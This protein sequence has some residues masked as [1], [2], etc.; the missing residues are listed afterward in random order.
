MKK[1][2]KKCEGFTLI[3]TI[4]SIA[5]I[6]ML[7]V[8][9]YNGY[10]LLIRN[11]KYG[12]NK[13]VSALVGKQENETIK[14]VSLN[15]EFK[16][17]N[18]DGKDI[19]D[20]G[21]GIK[22]TKVGDK[23]EGKRYFDKD[24]QSIEDESKKSYTSDITLIPKNNESG[25][26]ISLDKF[27][28][29]SNSELNSCDEYIVKDGGMIKPSNKEPDE[30]FSI[31]SEITIKITLQEDSSEYK[32]NIEIESQK[33]EFT[34][35]KKKNIQLNLDLKYCTKSVK[36][37]VKNETKKP[38]NLCILNNN[39]VQ[40]ENEKGVLNEYYRSEAIN[41]TGQLFEVNV[42]VFDVKD[43]T[44]PLYSSNFV[45]NIDIK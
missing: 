34:L 10:V 25:E 17:T 3:E 38:L 39:D 45:Q 16:V 26:K 37:I 32:G 28:N 42:K 43:E 7:S 40:V 23:Y 31:D 30:S 20:M 12:E 6:G 35:E 44:K 13:Q 5:I 24:G 36:V 2:S 14:S 8:G 9:V 29:I 1:K 21:Q 19:L 22:L 4:I 15:N 33:M 41:K 18:I 27:K 11:T